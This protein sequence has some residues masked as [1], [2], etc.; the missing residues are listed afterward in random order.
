MT[1]EPHVA[2][3]DQLDVTAWL[4]P[5]TTKK[6]PALPSTVPRTSRRARC[7]LRPLSTKT[8]TPTNAI[9]A[10][11]RLIKRHQ[12]HD[13][14]WVKAPPSKSPTAAPDPP[15]TPYI[16]KAL[17]RSLGS[18]KVTVNVARAAGAR[19]A[20]KTPWIARAITNVVKLCA[21]PPIADATA[22]PA[23]PT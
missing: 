5:K 22:K 23:S 11:N 20:P 3:L 21:K 10:K 7:S 9:A 14:H 13:A 15:M 4:K 16:A 17:A 8:A 6:S 2:R 12:R 1:S 18:V 19:R